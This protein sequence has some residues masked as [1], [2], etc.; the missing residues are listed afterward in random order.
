MRKLE[1][2]LKKLAKKYDRRLERSSRHL[3]L[4]CEAGQ[5]ETIYFSATP[6]DHRS[7]KNLEARLRRTHREDSDADTEQG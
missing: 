7:I 2:E 5:F 4:V 1:R 6:S 3:K